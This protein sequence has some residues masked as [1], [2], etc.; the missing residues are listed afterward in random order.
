MASS[1]C[2]PP[3]LVVARRACAC[4]RS[5]SAAPSGTAR[6]PR[7]PGRGFRPGD[8][9]RPAPCTRRGCPCRSSSAR[10]RRMVRSCCCCCPAGG[11]RGPPPPL[12]PTPKTTKPT[13]KLSA[14]KTKTHLAWR[15]SFGKNMSPS[16][17]AYSVRAGVDRARSRGRGAFRT[18]V[19]LLRRAPDRATLLD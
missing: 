9:R 8:R 13:E 7:S 16:T 17:P 5:P 1:R 6:R 15:R 3:A 2:W 18:G 12:P 10:R 11:R 14:R 19:W 4:T